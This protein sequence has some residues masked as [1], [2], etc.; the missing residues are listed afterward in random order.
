MPLIEPHLLQRQS[1]YL[2]LG[3]SDAS[4]QDEWKGTQ[5]KVFLV[6]PE[7]GFN[8]YYKAIYRDFKTSF[9]RLPYA[10]AG[11]QPVAIDDPNVLG[12]VTAE[13]HRQNMREFRVMYYPSTEQRHVH[14]HPFE[15]VQAGM[16]LI[17]LA[18][19]LLDRLGGRNLPGR[20]ATVKD[21]RQ[22]I[23][24]ILSGDEN[25]L[26]DIR[27]SQPIL[28]ESMKVENCEPH[29]RT[30]IRTILD[31]LA[32]TRSRPRTTAR[33]KRIAVLVPVAYRGGSL[34][35]AKLLAQAIAE[36]GEA[37]GE[38]VDVVFGHLD[39]PA[40]YP[41][42][43][44]TDLPTSVK[45]RPFKWRV[46]N[47][48]EA[49]RAMAYDGGDA[50]VVHPFYQAPDDDI[51]QFTDCDLWIVIS[52]RLEHPLPPI[53][54][55]LLMVYDYLQRYTKFLDPAMNARFIERGKNANAV[56]VTTE[57]TARDA[58]QFGGVPANKVRRVPMLAPLFEHNPG[59]IAVVDPSYFVWTT[60]LGSHKNHVT[61]L[62]ALVLYYEKHGGKLKC[63]ITGVGTKNIFKSDEFPHLAAIREIRRANP[64]LKNNVV[65]EGELSDDKYQRLLSQAAFL[66]HAAKIDNGTFSVVEA[67][68]LGT[69]A[70]SS[71]YPAMREIGQQFGL[72]LAWMDPNDPEDMARQL[73][74]M[75]REFATARSNLPSQE[76]LASQS[77]TNLASDYWSVIREYV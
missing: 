51:S 12:Y 76:R 58:Q 8:T 59:R 39:D 33:R 64:S 48:A 36:G 11:A 4:V 3:L 53:R 5:P 19:G 74:T 23:E 63:R 75:E 43:E 72:N 65:S 30:G 77:V 27:Q 73:K 44:F 18:G 69:P 52:D 70:L 55:T 40:S 20:A 45:R 32:D 14:Y 34:R 13:Q 68:S 71:D 61:A 1:V 31:R 66:W 9:D 6:L 35:G 37:A 50:T 17:F 2:P 41:D 10:V 26:R 57:F 15:A 47:Q 60:N 16:P 42:S 67:A 62:K 29:W 56:L 24:R 25:L 49:R 21:A 7:L 28:L 54:P 46:M 22:K 38:A